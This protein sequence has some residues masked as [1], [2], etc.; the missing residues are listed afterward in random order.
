MRCRTLL[1]VTACNTAAGFIPALAHY[2]FAP[3]AT[4]PYALEQAK[5]GMVYSWCIGTLCF[6]VMERI[7]RPIRRLRRL[8]QVPAFLL[9]FIG[10]A[11]LGSI[12]ATLLV[13][14]M[15]GAKLEFAWS[16]YL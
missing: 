5:W 15:G 11:M 3:H 13:V 10:L 4:L 16:I 7:V 2:V 9:T 8:W 12:P 1:L 6:V 14:A